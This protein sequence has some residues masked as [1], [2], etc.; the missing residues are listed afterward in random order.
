MGGWDFAKLGEICDFKGGSQPPKSNFIYEPRDGYIRFLQIRDFGSDK[1]HTYIPISKNNNICRE[2]DI[3]IGRYG[4]SVGKILT[5]KTGAYN[6][7]LMKATPNSKIISR[8]WLFHYLTSQLFQTS[9]MSVATRSAQDGFSKDDI[10]NFQVP[11]PPLPVQKAIV[12]KLDAAFA[13]IEQAIAAAEKN[14]ENAK[15]LFQSYLSDVFERGGEGWEETTLGDAFNV[16]DGTHD[17]PKFVKDGYPLVTSKNLKNGILSLEK[18]QYISADD[19]SKINERSNVHKF[20]VLFAMIGTIGNPVVVE[21]NPNFAIKNV[22]LFKNPKNNNSYFLR[23]YLMSDMVLNKMSRDAKG[24]T[25]KF[26]SLGYLR[27]FPISLPDAKQQSDLVKSIEDFE[28]HA[29]KM[30][31]TYKEK[32]Q[33][34]AQLKQSLLQ[35][36]FSGKLVDA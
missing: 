28:N 17:S 30:Q 9:L 1:N 35:Q 5:G 10:Y 12:A 19:Y 32:L 3:M 29:E 13:S 22:A 15:Q 33:L 20:D 8:E 4:A 26:V 24:A 31:F 21:K 11:L 7:A 25:Q 36:A 16:R 34:L 6:V 27:Q 2:D 14:A 23:Y 18:I